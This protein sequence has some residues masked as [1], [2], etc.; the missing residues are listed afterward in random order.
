M[1]DDTGTDPTRRTFHK[2][3]AL[4]RRDGLDVRDLAVVEDL[5]GNCW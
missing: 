3:Q 4:V 5:G 1:I 2:G